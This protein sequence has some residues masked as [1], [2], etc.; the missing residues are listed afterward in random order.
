MKAFKLFCFLLPF[1]LTIGCVTGPEAERKSALNYLNGEHYSAAGTQI[2]VDPAPAF[3]ALFTPLKRKE[4]KTVISGTV[5]LATES[6][7]LP[8]RGVKVELFDEQQKLIAEALTQ[9]DGRFEIAEFIANGSYTLHASYKTSSGKSAVTIS[10]YEVAGLF[11][12]LDQ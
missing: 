1:T 3:P 6:I 10:G 8:L 7:P 12:Q 11:L 9:V 2:L 5:V 4:K